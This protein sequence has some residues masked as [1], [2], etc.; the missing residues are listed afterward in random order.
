MCVLLFT[1]D[2][3]QTNIMA[4]ALTHT[5]RAGLVNILHYNV[6]LFYYLSHFLNVLTYNIH[7]HLDLT[8]TYLDTLA[9]IN[10]RYNWDTYSEFDLEQETLTSRGP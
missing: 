9:V 4:A 8:K 1:P 5:A 7:T 6:F 3:M 2:Q 10:L